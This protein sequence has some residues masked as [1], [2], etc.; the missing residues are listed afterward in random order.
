MKST[1]L[2]NVPTL[3]LRSHLKLSV[4]I[5]VPDIA[6]SIPSDEVTFELTDNLEYPDDAGAVTETGRLESSLSK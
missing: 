5:G 2:V 1:V 3:A 6:N 4:R